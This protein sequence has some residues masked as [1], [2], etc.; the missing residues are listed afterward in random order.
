MARGGAQ[1]GVEGSPCLVGG[2]IPT[3]PGGGGA[4]GRESSPGWVLPPNV[5]T[6]PRIGEEEGAV[7]TGEEREGEGEWKPE[8]SVPM[9]R[10]RSMRTERHKMGH[11]RSL[12]ILQKQ[13][14]RNQRAAGGVVDSP[15]NLL[16]RHLMD[17]REEERL[18]VSGNWDKKRTLSG[19]QF[20]FG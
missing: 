18:K 5:P 11:P 12:Q 8:A 13:R 9:V 19:R 2:R 20:L 6:E 16:R 3:S 7:L 4:D 10:C 15:K 1:R 17:Q 14:N